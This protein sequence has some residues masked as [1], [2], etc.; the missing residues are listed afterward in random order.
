MEN[1]NIFPMVYRHRVDRHGMVPLVICVT[2]NGKPVAYDPLKRRIPLAYWD[3]EK[4]E[5]KKGAP[6]A[7]LVNALIR[8][9]AAELDK[10]FTQQQIMGITVTKNRVK[11]QV[12]GLAPGTD[13]IQYC[14]KRLPE[15]Y[16][17][18]STLRT[19]RNEVRKLSGF[20][21]EIAFAD[22]TYDFLERYKKYLEGAGNRANT[23]WK[24]LKFLNTV[25]IDGIRRG[26]MRSQ[27][28]PFNHFDR[29]KYRSPKKSGLTLEQCVAIEQY[30]DNPDTPDMARRV[31]IYFLLMCYSGMRF[32]DAIKFD[33]DTQIKDGRLLVDTGKFGV[34]VNMPINHRLASIVDKMPGNR[35]SISNQAFN[36]WLKVVAASVKVDGLV[37]GLGEGSHKGR[38]TFGRLLATAGVPKPQA[39][40]LLGHLDPNSTNEYYEVRD[41]AL[42]N[43]V[44][45][46]NKIL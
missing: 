21:A 4:R 37:I 10:E 19:Y 44:K 38:H 32:A 30:A 18:G 2:L 6:N 31:A 24:S 8:K 28:N 27:D 20:Q 33:P 11:D 3:S 14:N 15:R 34:S 35:L 22:I 43:A 5:V 29:G 17:N 25:I 42:D 36:R 46:L 9:R 23:V 41:E 26:V 40:A 16:K 13:F 1:I 12:K 39:Q 45:S 7:S